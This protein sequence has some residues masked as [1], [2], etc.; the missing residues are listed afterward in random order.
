MS[1]T[2][3][4][5]DVAGRADTPR[6]EK[7]GVRKPKEEYAKKSGREPVGRAGASPSRENQREKGGKRARG[8]R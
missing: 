2:S 8:T 3:L 1:E 5:G 7:K 6:S 4:F